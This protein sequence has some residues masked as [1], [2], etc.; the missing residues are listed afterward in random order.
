MSNLK[1]VIDI[2]K[3]VRDNFNNYE[4]LPEHKFAIEYAIIILEG[5]LEAK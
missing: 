1:E 5:L 4:L 2:L 3:D